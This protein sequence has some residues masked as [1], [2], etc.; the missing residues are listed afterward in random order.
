VVLQW[1]YIRA[2]VVSAEK[3]DILAT[4]TCLAFLHRL[5]PGDMKTFSSFELMRALRNNL[6]AHVCN[7][8][9]AGG[10]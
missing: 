3:A 4:R 9:Y 10:C 5:L 2:T 7:Q 1:C 6:E 8:I